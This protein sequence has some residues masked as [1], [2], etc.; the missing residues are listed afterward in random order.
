MEPTSWPA[1]DFYSK[2]ATNCFAI[3]P[4]QRTNFTQLINMIEEELN[5]EEKVK[6]LALITQYNNP[7]NISVQSTTWNFTQ[8]GPFSE[9]PI[10]N[11][12]E[13]INKSSFLTSS[14]YSR[15]PGFTS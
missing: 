8:T 1:K 15:F 2:I 10:T 5:Q 9:E 12:K 3:H 4:N 14:G 7:G 11:S 13:P 6:Y